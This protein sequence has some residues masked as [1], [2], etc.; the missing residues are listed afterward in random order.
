MTNIPAWEVWS[1][2]AESLIK[3]NVHMAGAMFTLNL[4]FLRFL[5]ENM[6]VGDRMI[7]YRKIK[8]IFDVWRNLQEK[9]DN[10]KTQAAMNR[11][12]ELQKAR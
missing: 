3:I 4:D 8:A 5:F 11:T 1:T 7:F 10:P 6:N 12:K 9:K 2:H